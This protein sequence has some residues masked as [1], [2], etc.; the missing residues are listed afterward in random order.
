M[1]SSLRLFFDS[2][3]NS[4][5]APRWP[6]SQSASCAFGTDEPNVSAVF[7]KRRLA[8]RSNARPRSP[9]AVDS[10]PLNVPIRPYPGILLAAFANA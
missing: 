6:K 4:T 5:V 7:G 8:D 2:A 3:R 1:L 9:L 10:G